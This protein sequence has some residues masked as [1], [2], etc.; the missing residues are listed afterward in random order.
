MKHKSLWVG[1]LIIIAMTILLCL[2]NIFYQLQIHP[3]LRWWLSTLECGLIGITGM[4]A[5]LYWF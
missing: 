4:S 3:V 2:T 1:L 5:A